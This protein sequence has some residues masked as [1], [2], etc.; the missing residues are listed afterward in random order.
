MFN[1][2]ILTM[3]VFCLSCKSIYAGEATSLLLPEISVTAT[4]STKDVFSTGEAVTVITQEEIQ[5][6]NVAT[7][8]DLLRGKAGVIIQK[9]NTGG[10]SPFIRG[11]TGKQ[12]LLLVDGVRLNNS[13]YRFGPHQY[14]NTIDPYSIEKIEVVRGPGS[15]LYGSDALGGVINIITKA[16]GKNEQSIGTDGLVATRF[17]SADMSLSGRAQFEHHS[18]NYSIIGGF[19]GKHIDDLEGGG[20]VGRQ[21]PSAYDEINADFK[22]IYDFTENKRLT[23]SQGYTQQYDVPK[24]S[25]VTLGSKRKFNYEPQIRSLTY[26]EYDARKIKSSIFDSVKLNLSYNFQEEGEEIIDVANPL[27]ET[28]EITSVDTIGI[29]GS[30]NKRLNSMNMLAYGF[31][32]YFDKYD[33]SKQSINRNTG[34]A[35]TNNPGVPD[36]TEYDSFGVYIQDEISISE[37]LHITPSARYSRFTAEGSVANQQLNL[38]ATDITFGFN[39]VYT[40]HPSINLIAGV[41]EGFRAPNI[42]DFFGRVDFINE[43]PNTSLEPEESLTYELGVKFNTNKTYAEVFYYHS[44]YENLINRATVAPGVVQRQNIDSATIKGIET[45]ISYMLNDQWSIQGKLD[46]TYGE[47]DETGEYVRR[48]PPMNGSLAVQYR[49]DERLWFEASSLFADK[50]DKLS[51]GD[52]SDPR[53]PN[54]GTPGYVT[55]NLSSNYSLTNTQKLNVTIE[56]ILDKKYKTHGSGVYEPGINV[57]AKYELL[58]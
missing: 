20:D 23:F 12:I 8:P 6:S 54:G 44:K 19:T 47:N 3:L 48:V 45:S 10:G 52:V 16:R 9:T 37:R 36:N 24:T 32:Y 39:S 1:I 7:T 15:V 46:F 25:E 14:L 13:F 21:T 38:T 43:I 17:A 35:V 51:G 26:V 41:S 40:I 30:F 53:I 58:F 34:V 18:D 31:D 57:I 11:L 56:N 33:T 55:F 49:H 5:K 50:Q 27:T 28:Q 29:I 4:K 2:R 22:W 42:E